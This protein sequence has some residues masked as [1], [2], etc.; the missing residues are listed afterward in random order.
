[1]LPNRSLGASGP[2]AHASLRDE[3]SCTFSPHL[4][5]CQLPFDS[6]LE[7]Q[8]VPFR[9]PQETGAGSED[10]GSARLIGLH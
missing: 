3:I 7:C 5:T 2:P 10:S 6:T 8:A 1:M 4:T 9:A